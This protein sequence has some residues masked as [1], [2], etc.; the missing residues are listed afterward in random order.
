MTHAEITTARIAAV[1][2]HQGLAISPV[3]RVLM[4]RAVE[5]MSPE[6]FYMDGELFA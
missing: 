6:N 5:E 1:R 2:L 3:E 4:N